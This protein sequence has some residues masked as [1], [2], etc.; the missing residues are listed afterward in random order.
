MPFDVNID[1]EMNKKE[2]WS[3][4]E[5]R[6]LLDARDEPQVSLYWRLTRASLFHAA[7]DLCTATFRFPGLTIPER[8]ERLL[9]V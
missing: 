7:G 2:H 4:R 3:E 6:R 9:V 1:Y 5:N 8:E